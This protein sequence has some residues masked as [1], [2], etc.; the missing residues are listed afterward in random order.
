MG[1]KMKQAQ[2][3]ENQKIIKKYVKT[4]EDGAK[5]KSLI[6]SFIPHKSFKIFCNINKKRFTQEFDKLVKLG[7]YG[8]SY[9][10]FVK[11]KYD[12]NIKLL[13]SDNIEGTKSFSMY[14]I[15]ERQAFYSH[16]FSLIERI[17][18]MLG[19]KFTDEKHSQYQR[20]FANF[21]VIDYPLVKDLYFT[22]I[23]MQIYHLKESLKANRTIL[24]LT[25]NKKEKEKLKAEGIKLKNEIL[26]L[27]KSKQNILEQRGTINMYFNDWG[28]KTKNMIRGEKKLYYENTFINDKTELKKYPYKKFS[29]NFRKDKSNRK[30]ALNLTK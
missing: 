25:E 26:H 21:Q 11:Q 6:I 12:D 19:N 13:I 28:A 10:D 3:S 24:K 1:G 20:S 14:S 8:I 17:K 4:I 9:E 2:E 22:I 30:K 18:L 27:D 23:D 15:G 5:K 16:L 7:V 29:D